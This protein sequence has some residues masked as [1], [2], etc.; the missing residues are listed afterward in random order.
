MVLY[1]VVLG[2]FAV[3]RFVPRP[4]TPHL[5]IAS[6]HYKILSSATKAE[7][8][9]L[10]RAAENLYGAYS[11]A[12]GTLPKFRHV[13][14]KLQLKLYKDRAEF[15]HIH[16]GL[17]WAEAFY[18]SGCAQAYYSAKEVNPCQ[19]MLHE[20]VHQLNVE[21]ARL[22]LAKWLDEGLAEYFSTSRHNETNL[23]PGAIDPNTYPVWWI[24]EIATAPD[25]EK[26]I[27]NGSVIPLRQIITNHGGPSLRR[28]FNLY[29][30][31]WWTLTHFLMTT[32]RYHHGALQLLES[33]GGLEAFERFIGPVDQIQT[34]W[35]HH[36]RRIKEALDDPDPN[37]FKTGLLTSTPR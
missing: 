13:H 12:L 8:E 16:P 34:E 21:V 29:Y 7:T 25:L 28:H 32:P 26:A 14:P 22:D 24:D 27:R 9:E 19:W 15:R 5:K 37:F 33:G 2:C 36:V 3:W 18:K 10:R 17:G 23:A 20:A 11:N 6:D 4:W 30:L 35:F 1:L 31:H